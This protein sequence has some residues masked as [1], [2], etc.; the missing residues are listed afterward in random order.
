VRQQL[1]VVKVPHFQNQMIRNKSVRFSDEKARMAAISQQEQNQPQQQEQPQF[2]RR[3]YSFF[4]T[5]GAGKPEMQDKSGTGDTNT[6]YFPTDSPPPDTPQRSQVRAEMKRPSRDERRRQRQYQFGE[7]SQKQEPLQKILSYQEY[8]EFKE[9]RQHL[10]QKRQRQQKEWELMQME[11][12]GELLNEDNRALVATVTLAARSSTR[13]PVQTLWTTI[14][15]CWFNPNEHIVAFRENSLSESCVLELRWVA[16]SSFPPSSSN[17][18]RNSA[19]NFDHMPGGRNSFR[20]SGQG[21]PRRPWADEEGLFSSEEEAITDDD[22]DSEL[23]EM[24]RRMGV[25][26]GPHH[27]RRRSSAS[28]STA[29]ASTPNTPARR[30]SASNGSSGGGG[31]GGGAAEPRIF[32]LQYWSAAADTPQGWRTAR[33]SF[34]RHMVA[35]RVAPPGRRIVCALA[36]GARCEVYGWENGASVSNP[37]L[38]PRHAGTLDLRTRHG[39]RELEAQLEFIERRGLRYALGVGGSGAGGGAELTRPWSRRTG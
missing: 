10:E 11:E 31:G 6:S 19:P 30:G 37:G 24:M 5:P 14:L 39:R 1:R 16:P 17:P 15:S 29:A 38:V 3:R 21:V 9:F 36:V 34:A 8:Q 4:D 25:S 26:R 23:E 28:Y 20:Q 7:K 27:H 18:N 35:A 2:R 32:T 22:E 13:A 12:D 33:A